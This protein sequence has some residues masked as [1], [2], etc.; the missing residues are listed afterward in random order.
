MLDSPVDKFVCSN[1]KKDKRHKNYFLQK[2]LQPV[3]FDTNGSVQWM[4]PMQLRGLSLQEELLI[5]KSAPYI[6]VIHLYNGSLGLKGHC[7]V[8]ECESNGDICKLPRAES[9]TVCF[10]R[11]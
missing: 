10:N 7:V 9:D 2:N 5:Q 4:V 3:W 11:Q 1:C 8:F 6:P